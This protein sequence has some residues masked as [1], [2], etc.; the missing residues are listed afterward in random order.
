MIILTALFCV[1]YSGHIQRLLLYSST[2]MFAVFKIEYNRPE[3]DFF[4]AFKRMDIEVLLSRS[5]TLDWMIQLQSAMYILSSLQKYAFRFIRWIWYST[6]QMRYYSHVLRY[7]D[8]RRTY[9][10]VVG[11]SK[12]YLNSQMY[13]DTFVLIR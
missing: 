7:T 1:P 13:F 9:T 11:W 2:N 8:N 6:I 10:L 3:N 5:D 12:L 4:K